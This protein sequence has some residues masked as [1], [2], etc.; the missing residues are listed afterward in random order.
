MRVRWEDEPQ[1]PTPPEE[2]VEMVPANLMDHEVDTSGID[3]DIAHA[4]A[5]I[6]HELAE[7]EEMNEAT[8]ALEPKMTR[9]KAAKPKMTNV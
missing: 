9:R 2:P 5:M 3:A 1:V 4:M 8:D 6:D 7:F